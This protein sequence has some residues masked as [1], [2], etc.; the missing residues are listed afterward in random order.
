MTNRIPLSIG[1]YRLAENEI[2]KSFGDTVSITDK[3]KSLN[4][5]GTSDV[6]GTSFTTIAQFAS[7]VINEISPTTNSID[8]IVCTDNTFTGNVTVEGHTIDGSGNLTFVV[9]T[10]ACN[11]NTEVTLDTPLARATRVFNA[12]GTDLASTSDVVYVFDGTDG[13]T[14]GVPTTAADVFVLFTGDEN[15]SEKCQTATSSVDYWIITGGRVTVA[16]NKASSIEWRFEVRQ[17]DG[18]WRVQDN[19]FLDTSNDTYY[20]ELT[21]PYLIVPPN[22]DVRVRA[23]TNTQTDVSM[24]ARIRGVLAIITSG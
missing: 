7:G 20:D 10:K 6:V 18:V 4:K 9:Q 24:T 8:T 11:G 1:S 16:S 14:S 5:F 2:F 17:K 19:G 13:S 12:S 21:V 15:Q 22:S 23:K 3:G